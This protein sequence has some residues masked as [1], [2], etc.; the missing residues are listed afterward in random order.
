MT[1][2]GLVGL[3]AI[4][5]H[6]LINNVALKTMVEAIHNATEGPELQYYDWVKT[7]SDTTRYLRRLDDGDTAIYCSD[8]SS[9]FE[10]YPEGDR[11]HMAAIEWYTRISKDSPLLGSLFPANQYLCNLW[12]ERAVER[13]QGPWNRK[14]ANPVLVVANTLNPLDSFAQAESIA[15]EMGDN[16]YFVKEEGFAVGP[17]CL[18]CYL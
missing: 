17:S 6:D 2:A 8:Y 16:A 1:R 3:D 9:D 5:G 18:L 7:L 4:F 12:P 10:E 11:K 13:Y 15:R 14:P